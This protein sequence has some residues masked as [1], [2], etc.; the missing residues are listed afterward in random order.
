MSFVSKSDIQNVV[1]GLFE[2]V[3]AVLGKPVFVPFQRM[4]YEEAMEKHGTDKPDLRSNKDSDELAFVWVEDFPMFL[5][6]K[7]GGTT[8]SAVPAVTAFF[9]NG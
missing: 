9:Q 6:N 5:R 4:T 3:L 1:E 7:E 2:H 8:P